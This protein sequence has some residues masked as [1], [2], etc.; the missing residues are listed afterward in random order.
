[1]LEASLA[2]GYAISSNEIVHDL[3]PL[4][5]LERGNNVVRLACGYDVAFLA[6]GELRNHH[7]HCRKLPK[8][9]TALNVHKVNWTNKLV[10]SKNDEC[11]HKHIPVVSGSEISS[12][13]MIFIDTGATYDMINRTLV[14]GRMPQAVRDLIKPTRIN[15]A[16]GKACV[17]EG[18]RV[19]TAPW[20]C[21]ADAVLMDDSPN[22]NSVGQRVLNADFSFIWIK[23]LFPCFLSPCCRMIIIFDL[24]GV[25]PCYSTC[26]ENFDQTMLGSFELNEN[27]FRKTCGIIVEPDGRITLDLA[28][29]P[30]MPVSSYEPRVVDPLA[31]DLVD[32]MQIVHTR[33]EDRNAKRFLTLLQSAVDCWPI[34]NRRITRDLDTDLTIA[35]EIVVGMTRSGLYRSLP[36]GVNRIRTIFVADPKVKQAYANRPQAPSMMVMVE[37]DDEEGD[38]SQNNTHQ[39]YEDTITDKDGEFDIEDVYEIDW[40]TPATDVVGEEAEADIV[41]SDVDGTDYAEAE[42]PPPVPTADNSEVSNLREKLYAKT[43]QHCLT[44]TPFNKFCQGCMA[45]ARDKPHYKGSF[46][47]KDDKEGIITMDQMTVTEVNQPLGIG[48]YKYGIIFQHVDTD[49]WWFV[50]LRTLSFEES[51]FHFRNF[52]K[53][54]KSTRKSTLIYCDQQATLKAMAKHFGCA[55]RHPPPG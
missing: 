47:K 11:E 10:L 24:L 42:D 33:R 5:N 39:L 17:R 53:A 8:R 20:D 9:A 4:V 2:N 52:C 37:A 3:L 28:P 46:D 21:V 23:R 29:V 16:N 18:I 30:D 55:V 45:K 15:T 26:M 25:I 34:V 13:R 1:M 36:L 27:A 44:H 32:R 31:S 38:L 50:P 6:E 40:A 12:S 48:G 41:P 7:A 22:L 49:Y 35:D 43:K 19:R 51:D 54:T 14:Q